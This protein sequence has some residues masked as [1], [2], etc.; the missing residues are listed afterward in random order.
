[1]EIVGIPYDDVHQYGNDVTPQRPYFFTANENLPKEAWDFL[2]ELA[3]KY[4][5]ESTLKKRL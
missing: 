2:I 3:D 4:L 5:D 1:M